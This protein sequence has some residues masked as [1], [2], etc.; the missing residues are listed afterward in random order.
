MAPAL[1]TLADAP[2]NGESD[3]QLLRRLAR[4]AV[5][6]PGVEAASCSLLDADAHPVQTTATS[7]VAGQLELIQGDVR[8]GPGTDSWRTRKPLTNVDLTHQH[9]RVRWPHFTPRA[10]E[11]G[12]TTVTALPL[13]H[14]DRSLGALT[15][16]HPQGALLPEHLRWSTLLAD[17]TTAGLDHRNA[18]R[19]ATNREQQLQHALNSRVL[20]EQAKGILAERLDCTVGDAFDLLRHHA[21]RNHLKIADVAA[22][23]VHSPP[24]SGPFPR[25]GR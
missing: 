21:R 10:V 22:E 3:E 5:L 9:S 14:D 23:I 11:A 18:L 6:I 1:I 13:R 24:G 25:P 4:A 17:A 19:Q 8:E 20:I 12:V 15:L 2:L 16:H 7:D